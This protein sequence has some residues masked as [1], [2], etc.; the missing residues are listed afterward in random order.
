MEA[1]EEGREA[2]SLAEVLP[3]DRFGPL[4]TS[5]PRPPR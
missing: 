3:L 1:E 2:P 5:S 4:S